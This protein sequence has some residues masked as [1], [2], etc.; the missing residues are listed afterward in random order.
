MTCYAGD[1]LDDEEFFD[2]YDFYSSKNP[3]FPYD[4]YPQFDLG[5]MDD[6]ECL[7]DFRVH[8]RDIPALAYHLRITDNFYCQQHSVSDGIEGLC[9][10]LQRLSS[11]CRYGDM[12]LRFA[13]PVPVLSM[14]TNTVLDYIYGTHGHRIT[15]WNNTVMSPAHFQ[16][17]AN[18]V[19][20]KGSPLDNCFG[21]I[22]STVRP[23]CRPTEDQRVV[24][25]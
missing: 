24:Y 20:A 25:P 1:M 18:A 3:D 15:Q 2:L 17:Y 4:S 16:V 19:S 12:L 14:V 6:S 10:L 22:D 11:P 9:M 23:I 13:R 21:F 8:K 7:A 5:E